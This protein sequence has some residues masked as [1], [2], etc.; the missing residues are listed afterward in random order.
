MNCAQGAGW[1][2]GPN[3]PA[4]P[5]WEHELRPYIADSFPGVRL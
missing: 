4:A 1:G 2:I 5:H 3:A